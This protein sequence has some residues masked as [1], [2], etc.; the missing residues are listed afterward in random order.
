MRPATFIKRGVGTKSIKIYMFSLIAF[1]LKRWSISNQVVQFKERLKNLQTGNLVIH[2]TSN[3]C[4]KVLLTIQFQ[5]CQ[6]IISAQLNHYDTAFGDSYFCCTRI[7]TAAVTE[8][9]R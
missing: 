6:G 9:G 2:I 3:G 1:F 4:T 5:K 8:M 7:S